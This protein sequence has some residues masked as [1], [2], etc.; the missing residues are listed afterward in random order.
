MQSTREA[1]YAFRCI[2]ENEHTEDENWDLE[3]QASLDDLREQFVHSLLDKM[4]LSETFTV[5]AI[6]RQFITHINETEWPNK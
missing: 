1:V 5:D 4:S 6:I 3:D 2:I